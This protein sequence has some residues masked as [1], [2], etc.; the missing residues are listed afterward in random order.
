MDENLVRMASLFIRNRTDQT[1]RFSLPREPPNALQ[2]TRSD[3]GRAMVRR[4]AWIFRV[5][6]RRRNNIYA[7]G[8]AP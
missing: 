3:R 6:N 7:C 4:G 2:Y 1:A 8:A 5:R